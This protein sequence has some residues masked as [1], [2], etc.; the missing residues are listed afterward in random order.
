MTVEIEVT[1][2][3]SGFRVEV[4]TLSIAFP[5]ARGSRYRRTPAVRPVVVNSPVRPQPA[6]DAAAGL[7]AD[8]ATLA[9]NDQLIERHTRRPGAVATPPMPDV[10]RTSVGHAKNERH[11]VPPV[12]FSPLTRSPVAVPPPSSPFTIRAHQ[13][14]TAGPVG[15][16]SSVSGST[17]TEG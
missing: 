17:R 13:G 12:V 10:Q 5:S 15:S 16:R 6:P 7:G 2:R 4:V 8:A 14:A 3:L 9:V 1:G 11:H